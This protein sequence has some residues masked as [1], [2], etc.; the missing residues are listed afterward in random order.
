MVNIG[1]GLC[2][3]PQSSGVSG[4][5]TE[6]TLLLYQQYVPYQSVVGHR[7]RDAFS[8]RQSEFKEEYREFFHRETEKRSVLPYMRTG[9]VQRRIKIVFSVAYSNRGN[10]VRR[11]SC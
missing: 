6:D 8:Q 7:S 10:S 5:T 1:R 2:P 11:S 9:R 3:K 4:T